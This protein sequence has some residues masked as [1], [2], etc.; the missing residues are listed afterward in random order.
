MSEPAT[1]PPGSPTTWRAVLSGSSG[2]L[3]I[4]LTLITLTVATESL[5]IT[6]IMPAIVRD[7]G[8]ISL[9][10]LA[11]SAFFLA[12]LASIP[13]AGWA[14]DRYGQ[15]LPFAVL[16]PVFLPVRCWQP[17]PQACP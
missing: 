6:A 13:T 3:T 11:F 1:F 14:A 2:R 5:V 7:I 15:A 9:Y 8:G 10:G 17:L 4:G 12:G 16:I